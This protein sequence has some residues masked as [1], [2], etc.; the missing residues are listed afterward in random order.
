MD[1]VIPIRSRVFIV[2]S[3]HCIERGGMKD[4]DF[5]GTFEERLVLQHRTV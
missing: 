1:Q 4:S 3:I 2:G 5:V